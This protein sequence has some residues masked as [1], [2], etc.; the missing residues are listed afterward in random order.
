MSSQVQSNPQNEPTIVNPPPPEY[1][2][3][4]KSSRM[5]NQL[6]YLQKVVVKALWKH[7]FAWPFQQPVDAVK[8]NLPDYYQIIKK[9]MDL[10]TIKKRLENHYY[11]K[12]MECTEDLKT[13]FTNCYV[14]NRPGDDI[15]IM[16]Q[17]LEKLFLQKLAQMPQK[18][19]EFS[20]FG[21][22]SGKSKRRKGPAHLQMQS[23]ATVIISIFNSGLLQLQCIV[24]VVTV[25]STSQAKLRSTASGVRIPQ[26][27]MTVVPPPTKHLIV[28]SF[29]FFLNKVKKG[30]KRK[31]DTTTP[32][33]PIIATSSESSPTFTEPKPTKFPSRRESS[34]SI[35]PPKKDLPDSQQQH[36]VGKKEKLSERLKYCNSI[37]KG[38][39]S[40]K[41]AAYAWPFYKPVDV[42]ALGL[43]DYHDIIKLP[44]DL[45]TVKKRM[46]NREY[47]DTQQFATD[48]RL[49]FRNCYKYNPPDHEVVAMARKLQDVFEKHFA[50]IP[51]EPAEPMLT[52]QPK[53]Q[54]R[55]SIAS[56]N[57]D[58]SSSDS[59]NAS[60]N[61]EKERTER[62][63]KLQE[64]LKAVHDQLTALSQ[65]PLSKPKKKD[66]AKKEKKKKEKEK[67]KFRKKDDERKKNKSKPMQQKKS[68]KSST[69]S[70]LM[71][72][73]KQQAPP[74]CDSEEDNAK[75]MTY[76]EKRQ[77][78]LDINKL[79]GDKLGR[80]V[81]VIQSREP[82]LRDSNPDEIE[83]DFETLKPS[84]LRELERYVMTCLRKKPRKPYSKKVS[85][86]SKEEIQLEKKQELEKRLQDVSGHLNSGKKQTKKSMEMGGLSRLSE[87]SSSS[88]SGSSSSSND[89]SSSESSDSET[90]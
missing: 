4:K 56:E 88:K 85:G 83:I 86:R 81:H 20:V 87:S 75:P 45:T 6:Q 5:T 64:Q 31:A 41:H 74:V 54:V 42:E 63:A 89:S 18:E 39:F 16:A 34:R 90:G 78:S 7:H 62:L 44:M 61:S 49:M 46:E 32:T 35:K 70:R 27:V 28:S 23:A 73:N 29:T 82:S 53:T 48:V 13:M 76:D 72:K 22:K 51:D 69:G 17:T 80:V 40:K 38:M 77:L 15:V 9:P 26:P 59:E 2:N 30:I 43:H 84:T 58:E 14:Y 33:A 57:T 71:K 1:S 37:L 68:K 47:K 65:A 36:Q 55:K 66:K 10:G 8:L 25:C 52:S 67:D 3:L 79:P 11:W 12:S 60:E 24:L 19:I 21:R 50:K